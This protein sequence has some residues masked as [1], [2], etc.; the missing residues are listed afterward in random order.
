[1]DESSTL[2]GGA[3]AQ[4]V[5]AY[6]SLVTPPGA[7]LRRRW[8]ADG[9]VADLLGFQRVWGVAM[10]NRRDLP[11]YKYYTD[12]GG[13][14]PEVF[15][16][17]LD[18]RRSPDAGARVNGLCLPVDDARLAALDRRERN[19]ERIDVSEVVSVD[20][21]DG[22]RVWTYAGS[23]AGRERLRSGVAAGTAVIDANYLDGVRD[24][25]AL[26]GEPEHRA[27]AG[28]LDPGGL[29]VVALRRHEL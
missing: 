2:S 10:D 28:S 20:G 21:A 13:R 11:G 17:F 29:P 19:Y 18:V 1:V 25:F 22:I 27:C 12:T 16:T 4:F 26:L 14:R 6:G 7:A 8:S 24:G 23:A 5:F 9:F 15:V 3:I